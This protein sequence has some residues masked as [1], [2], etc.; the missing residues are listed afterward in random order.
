MIDLKGKN[1]IVTGGAV[2]IGREIA[3][4]LAEAGAD[5]A[6]TYRSHEPDEVLSAI[7]EKD[8]KAEAY[9]V[10]VTDSEQVRRM[11]HDASEA[12]G[13]QI[14][15][16]V[17]NAGGLIGRRPVPE[18]DDTHWHSVLDVN[19]SSAFYCTRAVLPRMPEGGRIVNI[20]SVAAR[21]GGGPGAVAYGAAK[22]GMHGMT[23]GLAKEL[24][25]RRITVNAV[26]PGLILDTPF[27][28]AF[29]P[30]E[31]QRA[32][33]EATPLRTA[34]YPRDVAGAVLYL[35]SDLGSFVTGAVIDLNGGTYFS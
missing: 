9:R 12:L 35:V 7:R 24:G 10:D 6:I 34:G 26:A 29:T 30:E 16:L 4:S 23:R 21:N 1:A 13:G 33:I 8:R 22:A 28:P 27:H 32:T 15:I 11:V 25:P 20:S 18:L 5:V 19:L 3:I 31:S 14:N 2:G 17:N